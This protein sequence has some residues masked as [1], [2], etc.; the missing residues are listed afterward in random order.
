MELHTMIEELTPGLAELQTAT[1]NA[2]RGFRENY[3]T[4]SIQMTFLPWAELLNIH[5]SRKLSCW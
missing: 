5:C 2:R 1:P 3:I 4:N